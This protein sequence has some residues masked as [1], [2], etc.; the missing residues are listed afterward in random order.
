MKIEIYFWKERQ[1]SAV[2]RNYR[3]KWLTTLACVGM[4]LVLLA[5][6][7][8]TNTESGRGCG[9]DWPLCNGKFVPAYTV[10]SMIEYSH[11]AVT[12]VEG[13]IVLAS[14]IAVWFG[15]KE[16][17]DSLYYALATLF[18]TVLQ[19]A[20]GAMAVIWEPTAAVMASHFG[21]SLLAFASSLL[22]AISIRQR[23]NSNSP[24]LQGDKAFK[25]SK[26]FRTGV[27]L[28]ALY[29]FVVVYIGAY[30]RHTDSGGGCLGWPLCNGEVV[31]ELAGATGIAFVHRIAAMLL[32][33]VIAALTYAAWSR[34]RGHRAIMMGCLWALALVTLQVF[35]GAL[36]VVTMGSELYLFSI[37]LHIMLISGLFA[38]LSFLCI[39]TYKA[40]RK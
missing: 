12:G 7:V 35:S 37:L 1:V 28:T 19:A 29:T 13:I 16:R 31:P 14:V 39:A 30:V 24:I 32:W 4:F 20:L 22:L 2:N 27:W 15:V 40:A 26:G 17:R 36:L 21:I 6:A 11:R 3:L 33:I 38:V 5:G 23:G 18:F 9:T 25:V 10:E 8:V 34:Y